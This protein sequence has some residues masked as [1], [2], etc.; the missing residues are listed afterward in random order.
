MMGCCCCRDEANCPLVGLGPV[1]GVPS[2]GGL[3]DF[4]AIY[5]SFG[6]NHGKL[7]KTR[8]TSATGD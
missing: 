6:E 1:E 8:S 3:R 4:A 5:V 7:R 2:V